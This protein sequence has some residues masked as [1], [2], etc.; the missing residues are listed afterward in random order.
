MFFND[1]IL[2]DKIMEKLENKKEK[3]GK[4]KFKCIKCLSNQY[5]N[6][7]GSGKDKIG[8]FTDYEC[9]DCNYISRIYNVQEY[10]C[11][12]EFDLPACDGDGFE[13]DEFMTVEEGTIW[14]LAENPGY[15]FISGEIR[16]ESDES[17]WIEISKNNFRECFEGID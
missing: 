12:K 14:H 6:I 16:L 7:V 5:K 17:G 4:M 13:T 2:S 9:A 15:R 11:I 10:R 3:G 1:D 8:G